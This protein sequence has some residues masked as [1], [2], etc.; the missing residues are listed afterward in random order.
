MRH[1][2]TTDD[3]AG[4]SAAAGML[5]AVGGRTSHAAV[6]AR[7]LDCPC[8]AACRDLLIDEDEHG[9]VIGG[10]RFEEGD[11]ITIDG[12]TGRVYA[13]TV[14]VVSERPDALI[15]TVDGWREVMAG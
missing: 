3:V 11:V 2:L 10:R 9:C 5:T 4:L 14:P 15:E 8:I 12:D 1:D 7:Q 13:G 6:V